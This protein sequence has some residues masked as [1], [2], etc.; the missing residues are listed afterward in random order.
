VVDILAGGTAATAG[1]GGWVCVASGV[2]FEGAPGT[3]E[4]DMVSAFLGR[5]DGQV[6]V[7]EIVVLGERGERDLGE[8]G[9]DELGEGVVDTA[10]A[11]GRAG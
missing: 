9:V 7:G 6:V 5:G 4:L 8:Q 11:C 10:R 3:L 1:W 2:C